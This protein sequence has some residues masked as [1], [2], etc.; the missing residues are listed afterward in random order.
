[1]VSPYWSSPSGASLHEKGATTSDQGNA[2]PGQRKQSNVVILVLEIKNKGFKK[3]EGGTHRGIARNS[4]INISQIRVCVAEGNY[5]NVH[6]WS[7]SN[8][9]HK[10][11]LSSFTC[12][13]AAS[14]SNIHTWRSSTGSDTTRR[15][16]S[17]KAFWIWLVNVP[18]VNLPATGCA[19]VY[20]ANFKMARYITKSAKP[21][22]LMN[23]NEYR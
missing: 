1:M 6:I 14:S 10:T 7:L 15:R 21:F 12:V 3:D 2:C 23:Y 20:F 9:L 18:G 22:N 19:P 4:N 8:W 16:G 11:Q 13:D 17:R 5:R